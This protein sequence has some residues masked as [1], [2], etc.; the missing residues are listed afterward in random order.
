MSSTI[1]RAFTKNLMEE[2]NHVV[3]AKS[4]FQYSVKSKLEIV[5]LGTC[6]EKISKIYLKIDELS[7]DFKQ[8]IFGRAVETA[9]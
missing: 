8:N 1:K 2:M 9:L 6:W 5:Y 3:I 4:D 7:S